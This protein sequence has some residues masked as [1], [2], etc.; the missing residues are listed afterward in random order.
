MFHS[1]SRDK[2]GVPA[3]EAIVKPRIS[4][5]TKDAVHFDDGTYESSVDSL[6]LATGYQVRIPFLEGGALIVDPKAKST[7]TSTIFP[8]PRTPLSTNLRY[9]RPLYRQILSLSTE[10]PPS[11]LYFVGLPVNVSNAPS[12][13]AQGLFIAHTLADPTLIPPRL[14]LLTELEES[15][16]ALRKHGYDPDVIG[17][18]LVDLIGNGESRSTYQDELIDF[19]KARNVEGL[20]LRGSGGLFVDD[21][22]RRAGLHKNMMTL[23]Q[24]W[25]RLE[26]IGAGEVRKWLKGRS[27]EEDWAN[28]L[29]ELL[30]WQLEHK[31]AE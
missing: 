17:H 31:E 6:I 8:P 18:S 14:Q 3:P 11:A 9:I 27:T 16:E 2:L 24:T 20:P 1:R 12:D 13:Q 22:R 19:L 30:A 25:A 29:D 4:Y 28:L 7:N 23:R 5:F 10:F 15:E 21:W 26:S